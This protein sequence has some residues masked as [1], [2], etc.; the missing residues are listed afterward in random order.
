MGW[1][2]GVSANVADIEALA[3]PRRF[4]DCGHSTEPG[5]AIIAALTGGALDAACWRAYD[6]LQRELEFHSRKDDP[7]AQA[8]SRKLRMRRRNTARI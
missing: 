8:E 2:D 6:K 1:G 4:H 7:K 3:E 5:C